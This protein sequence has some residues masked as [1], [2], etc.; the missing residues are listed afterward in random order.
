MIQIPKE[1]PTIK[2]AIIKP[3]NDAYTNPQVS[4]DKSYQIFNEG[5][6]KAIQDGFMLGLQTLMIRFHNIVLQVEK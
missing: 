1:L 4:I 3:S 6:Q 2:A 5:N